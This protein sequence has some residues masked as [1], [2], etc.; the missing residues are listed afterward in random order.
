[1]HAQLPFDAQVPWPL[2]VV[3]AEQNVQAGK[4]K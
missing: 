2:H 1:V 4:L 3:A